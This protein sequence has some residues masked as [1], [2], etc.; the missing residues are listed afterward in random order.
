MVA[1]ENLTSVFARVYSAF[2]GPRT[3]D[4]FRAACLTLTAQS[5]VPTAEVTTVADL[6]RLHRDGIGAS[7]SSWHLSMPVQRKVSEA[8]MG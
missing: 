3:D 4:I 6:P 5:A 8:W 7:M 1:V 2:W